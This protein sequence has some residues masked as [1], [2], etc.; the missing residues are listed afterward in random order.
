MKTRRNKKYKPRPIVMPQI[1]MGQS[2]FDSVRT[3]MDALRSCFDE[4]SKHMQCASQNMSDINTM[5]QQLE[6]IHHR[7]N[8]LV[9]SVEQVRLTHNILERFNNGGEIDRNEFNQLVG[10]LTEL[11]KAVKRIDNAAVWHDVENE[12]SIAAMVKGST[13]ENWFGG[14]I[15]PRNK[16][17][18]QSGPL[19]VSKG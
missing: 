11:V 6:R 10:T 5:F 13:N 1:V 3:G 7:A 14:L 18:A 8:L 16:K 4:P 15:A 9:P 19:L 2:M 17:P 12:M